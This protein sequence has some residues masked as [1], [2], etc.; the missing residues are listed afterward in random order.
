MA[1]A[2][3]ADLVQKEQFTTE[4]LRQSLEKSVF[5]NAGLV[6][7]D[8]ELNRLINANIGATASFAY[9]LDP[10]FT[11]NISDDSDNKATPDNIGTGED[12]TRFNYRNISYG[13]KQI[14]ANLS[15][16]GDPMVAIAGRVANGWAKNYDAVM[17]SMVK[18]IIADNIANDGS[19]MVIES[20]DA[21]SINLLLD[22]IQTAG[23]ASDE[24]F[25][26]ILAHSAVRNALR[27]QGVTDKIF[28]ANGKF[29]YES[30]VGLALM[31]RDGVETGVPNAGDYSTYLI[32]SGFAGFANGSPKIPNEVAYDALTGNGGGE[33]VVVSRNHFAL[34][35]YG[36]TQVGTPASTSP[37][38]GEFEAETYWTRTAE[39]KAISLACLR[40]PLA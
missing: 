37:T 28:D 26:G 21:V 5:W 24:L 10:S 2:N 17:Q 7:S 3:L 25:G 31:A 29:L 40:S 20:S 6:Q 27:K 22:L 12:V 23:D 36:F 9:F 33:E 38:N 19:D 15:L 16:T 8:S 32:G 1:V 39:R 4:V 35:P 34:H 11:V 18:G 13:A 30:L 14:T